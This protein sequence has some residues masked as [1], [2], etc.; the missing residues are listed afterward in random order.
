MSCLLSGTGRALKSLF[1]LWKLLL[2]PSLTGLQAKAQA[3]QEV[4]LSVCSS[5]ELT[6]AL[7]FS[8]VT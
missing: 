3:P 8:S 5:E 1:S 6:P 7:N 4:E 2:T